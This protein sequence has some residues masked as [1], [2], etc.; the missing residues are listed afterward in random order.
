MMTLGRW[1]GGK[2]VWVRSSKVDEDRDILKKWEFSFAK[3]TCR[4]VLVAAGVV[5]LLPESSVRSWEKKPSQ[6]IAI[7]LSFSVK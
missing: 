6:L 5:L 7:Q 3:N 4:S 2:A 1:I